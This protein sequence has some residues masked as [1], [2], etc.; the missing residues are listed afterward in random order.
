MTMQASFHLH[1]HLTFVVVFTDETR[2]GLVD[3][4]SD[5]LNSLRTLDPSVATVCYPIREREGAVEAPSRV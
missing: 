5:L 2:G 3:Q 4:W 1:G